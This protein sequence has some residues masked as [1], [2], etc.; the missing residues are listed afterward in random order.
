VIGGEVEQ[1]VTCS[2]RQIAG[3]KAARGGPSNRRIGRPAANQD[4]VGFGDVPTSV[5]VNS[6]AY[7]R[8][9]LDLS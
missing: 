8:G 3:G 4:S 1:V 5:Q 6:I 7:E 2:E 9:C